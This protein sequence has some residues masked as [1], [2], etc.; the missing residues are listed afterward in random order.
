MKKS[1][2]LFIGIGIIITTSILLIN[3]KATS[4]S[5]IYAPIKEDGSLNTNDC[6]IVFDHLKMLSRRTL[7]KRRDKA[8]YANDLFLGYK[9]QGQILIIE[10]EYNVFWLCRIKDNGDLLM[11]SSDRTFRLFKAID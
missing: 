8:I 6:L 7:I 9:R 1:L 2:I 4:I 10:I 11:I 3:Q 5:G